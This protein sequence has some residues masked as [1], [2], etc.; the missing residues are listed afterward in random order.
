M[1]TIIFAAVATLGLAAPASATPAIHAD[2]AAA[3]AVRLDAGQAEEFSSQYR[4]RHWRGYRRHWHRPYR[5]C[6]YTWRY[7]R[8]ILV[9]R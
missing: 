6:W 2:A 3:A 9:C 7:G 8:R 1:V 5:H 4:H